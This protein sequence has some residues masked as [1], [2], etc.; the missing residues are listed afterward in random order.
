[1][2]LKQKFFVIILVLILFGLLYVRFAGGQNLNAPVANWAD[3]KVKI[4]KK[5][6]GRGQDVTRAAVELGQALEEAIGNPEKAKET[7]PN[8]AKAD[9]CFR[10]VL[11]RDGMTLTESIK[12][13]DLIEEFATSTFE[14]QR[15]YVRYNA[16]LSGGVYPLV[17]SDIVN[18]NFELIGK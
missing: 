16:N 12:E 11:M 13:S 14:R 10:A 2:S 7:Q 18:C 6:S 9:S 8:R 15:R 17:E 3:L 1:M 5:Y 4:E